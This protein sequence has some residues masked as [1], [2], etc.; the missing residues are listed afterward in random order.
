MQDLNTYQTNLT[1]FTGRNSL[2][3]GLIV[4]IIDYNA[5][6]NFKAHQL[7]MQLVT[8]KLKMSDLLV[9]LIQYGFVKLKIGL[10]T[11]RPQNAA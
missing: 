11:V 2:K 1:S 4:Q 5:V 9:T 7:H 6:I 10:L 8:Y 3:F